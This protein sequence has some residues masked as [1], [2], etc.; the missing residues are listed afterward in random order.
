MLL[1][2]TVSNFGILPYIGGLLPVPL[3]LAYDFHQLYGVTWK[4]ALWKT[5]VVTFYMLVFYAIIILLVSGTL[6]GVEKSL[7]PEI[8]TYL[9]EL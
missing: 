4:R 7:N 9:E 5:I 6:F 2:W 8:G 1:T 3:V